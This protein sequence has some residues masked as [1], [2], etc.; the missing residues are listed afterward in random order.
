M[1]LKLIAKKNIVILTVQ[2]TVETLFRYNHLLKWH[3]PWLFLS[4]KVRC[5]FRII[6]E[7][8][9]VRSLIIKDRVVSLLVVESIGEV[10]SNTIAIH[11]LQKSKYITVALRHYLLTAQT[12]Q[13]GKRYE[14]ISQ[15]KT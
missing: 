5:V 6:S 3:R 15:G 7:K 10:K 4:R 1:L 12:D 8:E 9:I 11:V 13:F 2:Q 14:L